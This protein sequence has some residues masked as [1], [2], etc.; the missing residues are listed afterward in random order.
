[1]T[2]TYLLQDSLRYWL[3]EHEIEVQRFLHTYF[4]DKDHENVFKLF[5]KNPFSG[6]TIIEDFLRTHTQKKDYLINQ[7]IRGSKIIYVIG[8]RRSGKTAL[9]GWLSEQAWLSGRK[10]YYYMIFNAPKFAKRIFNLSDAT[11]GSFVV[12][13]ESAVVASSR[14]SLKDKN[15]GITSI[16]PILGHKDMTFLVIT[17]NSALSDINFSRLVDIKIFKTLSGDALAMEREATVN[18]LTELMLPKKV[19]GQEWTD[20]ALFVENG[21]YVKFT[22][23][24]CKNWSENISKSYS[25]ITEEEGLSFAK[26]LH[27]NE[28]DTKSIKVLLDSYGVSKSVKSWEEIFKEL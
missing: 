6:K 8:D 21:V 17:Q 15:K 24:L 7:C 18:P 27:L 3:V 2:D 13:D 19:Q 23:G 14:D 26:S 16:L 9:A 12:I 20:E 28:W 4:D 1:M 5:W 22:H 25:S 10:V 11:D